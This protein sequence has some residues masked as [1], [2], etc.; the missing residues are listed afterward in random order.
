MLR[1]RRGNVAARDWRIGAPSPLAHGVGSGHGD[2]LVHVLALHADAQRVGVHVRS[3]APVP[4][5][6]RGDWLTAAANLACVCAVVTRPARRQ[7][8]VDYR[9][10]GRR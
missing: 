10:G 1:D 5:A 2:W 9:R 7:Q 8:R 4:T 3:R 6:D